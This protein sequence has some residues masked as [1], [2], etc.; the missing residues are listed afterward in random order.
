[1]RRGILIFPLFTLLASLTLADADQAIAI[2]TVSG[3]LV[4]EV[5]VTYP[6]SGY[7]LAPA[8]KILGG[9]GSGA[10]AEAF[11]EDGE[12]V[13]I[14][15]TSAGSNYTI[16]PL[17]EIDPPPSLEIDM[18]ARLTVRGALGS[19]HAIEWAESLDGQA[20][21]RSFTN[22]TLLTAKVEV[23][24]LETPERV[25]RYYRRVVET[26]TDHPSFP[27]LVFVPPGTFIMG[28]PASEKGA[29]YVNEILHTVTL[30]KGFWM[31]P[32]EVTQGEYISIMGSNPS[33]FKNGVIALENGSGGRVTNELLHPVEQV[34]WFDATNYCFK[35]T[36]RDQAERRIPANYFY[37]LPTE[38]EWEYACRGGTREA[39]S[40]GTAIRQGMANFNTTLEYDS[41][42]GDQPGTSSVRFR[43]TIET[44]SYSPNTFGLYDMHGNVWEWC[45]DW[46]GAYP[47]GIVKNPRGATSGSAR[48][49]RGGAFDAFGSYSRA[50]NRENINPDFKGYDLGFRIV[51]ARGR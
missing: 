38:A 21:W 42:I 18:V 5:T 17:I 7:T 26:A 39:F 3:G 41:A 43:R 9:S 48:V 24:D 30:T 34:S 40:F 36:Q 32:R 1:M 45:F 51:L 16:A 49:F 10:T 8:V 4:S 37:R 50:G 31:G 25:H 14:V 2:A 46:Y 13:Q 27:G 33:Y 47:P 6:G 15:A 44:G 23:L 29:T 11:V 20:V 22:I 19:L 35:L 12:V 28:S